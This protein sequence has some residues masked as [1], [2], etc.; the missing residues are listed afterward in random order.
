M[1]TGLF[2]VIGEP[3]VRVAAA[4]YAL[5]PGEALA[6]YCDGRPDAPF[7]EIHARLVTDWFYRI[8]ALRLAEAYAQRRRGSAYVYEFAWQ[9]RPSTAASARATPPNSPSP[10]TP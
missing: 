6:A 1:P 5:D 10:S 2:G 4:A 3:A 7:G 8:P 9:P